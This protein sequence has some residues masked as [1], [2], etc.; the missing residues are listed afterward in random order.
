M[1]DQLFQ[2]SQPELERVRAIV[3]QDYDPL[4]PDPRLDSN[5]HQ[6]GNVPNPFEARRIINE[7]GILD[8]A[9]AAPHLMTAIDPNADILLYKAWKD[10]LGDYPKYP[11]QAIGDCVSM[12]YG[13]GTDLTQ[14]IQTAISG[15]SWKYTEVDTEALYGMGREA[16]NMLGG[17]DGC[18]GAAMA[19]AITTMGTVSRESVGPYSGQRAKQFGRSGAPAAIK[20][21]ARDHMMGATAIVNTLAEL[22]A[23]LIN[24]YVAP[25]CSNQGYGMTRD[26]DGFCYPRGSWSHCMLICAKRV[27][28]KVGYLIAQSWGPTTPSGPLALDQPPFTF[29]VEP[30]PI[31]HMLA[32]RDTFA[33]SKFKGWPGV[34]PLPSSWT[35]DIAA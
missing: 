18:Y 6:F 20:T 26:S 11:A 19:K 21:A 13:H 30:Q 25:V 1:P 28:G 5:F 34:G 14:A 16:G 7:L 9:D 24:G 10:V 32:A 8:F 31:A 15:E 23:A 12:G 35:Y 29:W 2:Y 4:T 22:D 3:G 27:T 33:L 17:G